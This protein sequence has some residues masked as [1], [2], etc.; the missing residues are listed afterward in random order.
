M[1]KYVLNNIEIYPIFEVEA[2]KII[3]EII[4]EANKEN[5]Q[6]MK[7]LYPDFIDKEGNLKAVVQCF[8]LK[9]NKEWILVDACNGNDKKR[10]D[11]PEWGNLNTNFIQR[12]KDIGVNTSD[13]SYVICSHLHTDH[14]GWLTTFK[15]GEWEPTFKNATHIIV[16]NEFD[17]WKSKPEIE[18][19]DDKNAFDDSIMPLVDNN[20]VELVE[21]NYILNEN[22][23]LIS[24]PGHT[25]FHSCIEIKSGDK[26]GLICG[27]LFHHPCQITYIDWE[28]E[29]AYSN[30]EVIKKRQNMREYCLKNNVLLM[31]SHFCHAGYI[32]KYENDEYIFKIDC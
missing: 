11:I 21:E 26:I 17:Y 9:V 27:D 1:K 18:I 16:K 8:L 2:G 7:Y 24:A 5:I 6:K 10:S 31:G 15:N 12:L 4:P 30:G 14:I 29:G 3:Q 25:P 20:L 13:I 28:T 19:D 22:V 32:S 23:R